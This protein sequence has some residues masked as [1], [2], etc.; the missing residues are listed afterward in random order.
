ML[1]LSANQVSGFWAEFLSAELKKKYM[2]DLDLFLESEFKQNKSIYPKSEEYFNALKWTPFKDVKVVILGQDP[3]HGE[4][5]AHGLS[6]S[7]PLGVKTPPSL[8]NIF[9]EL[10]GDLSIEG[11]GEGCL[12]SWAE[13]GVLL[14]NATLSVE[15][16][17]PG[18][19]QKKGWEELTDKI[20]S[21]LSEKKEHLVFVLWGAYAQRK[22][23]LIDESRH[24]VIKSAHPSP[25]SAYRGFLGSR[26]F[27]KINTHLKDS[28][29]API[30]W[31]IK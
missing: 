4:G 26:P 22:A 28:S 10:K 19:H 29:A 17:K 7:V 24:L 13:Q 31:T 3:Y 21:T 6:F 23:V 30:D 5:Q 11:S 27:S 15:A 8:K 16:H 18:S 1:K 14:L 20:I 2:K 12:K 25:L 9:K